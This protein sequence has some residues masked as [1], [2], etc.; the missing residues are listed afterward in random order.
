MA[1]GES[2][3]DGES[4]R[5]SDLSPRDLKW[6]EIK[7]LSQMTANAYAGTVFDKYYERMQGCSGWLRFA[8]VPNHD[9][10][11]VHKLQSTRLCH[12]RHCPIC[13][14]RR[15]LMWRAKTFRA[16][17]RIITDYP[18]KRFIY[19]T[20]TVRNCEVDQLGA[21]LTWMNKSWERLTHCKD[22]P[23]LGWL[24]A[25]EVTRGQDGSAHPHFHVL[26]MVNP[27]YF[28]KYYVTQQEWRELWRRSLRVEYDPQ[29]D[30]KVV[31]PVKTKLAEV[32]EPL[33]DSS[34][35]PEI[36]PMDEGLVAAIRYT[37]KYSTKPDE[38]L[39]LTGSSMSDDIE[40]Y[41][42]WLIEIT[43]QMHKRKSI[44]LGGIF[45]KYMSEN[46]PKNLIVDEEKVEDS[47]T[48]DEDPRVTYVWR[49]EVTQYL[50]SA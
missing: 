28:S 2:S 4:L 49:D 31:K 42:A 25:T 21:T 8:L 3:C 14:W 11:V 5:L 30:I 10:E 6:E 24:R 44:A 27:S 35:L 37:L 13:Q 17:R 20:L 29:V 26:M 36:K 19:L 45:K 7:P 38:F 47:E 43:S 40:K 15:A 18:R 9:G 41:Q 33:V 48:Q 12:V 22:F 50:M 23:A 32:S 16:L 1:H 39:F 34:E 46:D